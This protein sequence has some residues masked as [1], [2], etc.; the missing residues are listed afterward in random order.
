MQNPPPKKKKKTRHFPH[1]Q[2]KH[3]NHITL[4]NMNSH[5]LGI[6]ARQDAGNPISFN[7]LLRLRHNP[8]SSATANLQQVGIVS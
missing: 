4:T 6:M 8:I 5:D 2:G 1:K 3:I 7:I